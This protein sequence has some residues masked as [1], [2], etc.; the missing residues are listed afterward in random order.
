MDKATAALQTQDAWRPHFWRGPDR[1]VSQY[2]L[3]DLIRARDTKT[4]AAQFAAIAAHPARHVIIS[5]ESLCL[6]DESSLRF[7]AGFL[8]DAEVTIVFVWRPLPELLRAHW[9]ERLRHGAA[10]DFGSFLA[11]RLLDPWRDPLMNPA[12][13]LAPY[14]SVFGHA[15]IRIVSYPD[16]L[17]C[18]GNLLDAVLRA[19]GLM[20]VR[21]TERRVHPSPSVALSE[22]ARALMRIAHAHVPRPPGLP[23]CMVDAVEAVATSEP[24][25]GIIRLAANESRDFRLDLGI[26]PF[27]SL[28]AEFGATYRDRMDGTAGLDEAGSRVETLTMPDPAWL[29]HPDAVPGLHALFSELA[30]LERTRTRAEML[31]QQ[32][33]ALQSALDSVHQSTSWRL[34][35]PLRR[36]AVRKWGRRG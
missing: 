27:R 5:A 32:V 35:A 1:S 24:C 18:G 19:C 4:L 33:A 34:T 23:R 17:A 25:A 9:Q 8:G 26:E 7:L 2:E 20:P 11:D 28:H 3:P 15:A 22:V 30:G 21:A 10:E 6:L 13:S 31:A 36:A 14:A 12:L 29:L 16:C